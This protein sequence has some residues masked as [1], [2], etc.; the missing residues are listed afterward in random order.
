MARAVA[1][2]A[3]GKHRG[4]ARGTAGSRRGVNDPALRTQ[5]VQAARRY[6]QIAAEAR[7]EKYR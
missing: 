6:R 3:P 5:G 2:G 7:A 4:E 1:C